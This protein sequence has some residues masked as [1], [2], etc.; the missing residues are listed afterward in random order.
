MADTETLYNIFESFCAFG[1]SRNL[2]QTGSNSNLS[3]PQMDNAKFAK[4]TRD[5]NILDKVITPTE[6]DIT[7]SKVKGKTARKINFDEFQNALRLIATKKFASKP[8]SEAYVHLVRQI[9]QSSVGPNVISMVKPA[10]EEIVNRLN[11]PSN[12]TGTQK[13]K[14]EA[15]GLMKTS[16]SVQ[17]ISSSR[18]SVAPNNAGKRKQSSIATV[19]SEMLDQKA[20]QPKK[21]DSHLPKINSSSKPN[22]SAK[23][24]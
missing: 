17:N 21:T 11:N 12:F 16:G 8:S 1:S 4:F 5:T 20:N 22:L 15:N 13:N 23:S 3:G 18:P 9:C 19:S 10:Q 24:V 7:F 6:V 14:F 2:S